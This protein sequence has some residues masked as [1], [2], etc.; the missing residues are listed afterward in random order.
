[1]LV[2]ILVF[3]PRFTAILPELMLPHMMGR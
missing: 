2:L 1:V 3:W